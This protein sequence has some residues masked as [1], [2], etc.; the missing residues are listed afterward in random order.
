MSMSTTSGALEQRLPDD[1]VRR[2]NEAFE[3]LAWARWGWQVPAWPDRTG[4][5]AHPGRDRLTADAVG[6]Q[7]PHGASSRPAAR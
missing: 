3:A 5:R 7:R 1:G 2:A 6:P 4:G